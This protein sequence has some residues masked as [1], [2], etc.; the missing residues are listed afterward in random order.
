[1]LAFAFGIA[2]LFGL[3][4]VLASGRRRHFGHFGQGVGERYWQNALFDRLGTSS[5][6]EKVILA[7]ISDLQDHLRTTRDH[8]RDLR[9]DTAAAL[10]GE[11]FDSEQV[12]QAL[13]AHDADLIALRQRLIAFM[14]V[15]HETLD[16]AQRQQVARWIEQGRPG[17]YGCGHRLHRRHCGHCAA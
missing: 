15:V 2:C 10:R 4:V 5:A 14:A 13:A 3:I 17:G 11:R 7:G 8:M 12:G 16:S 6:Q 9:R 1:M